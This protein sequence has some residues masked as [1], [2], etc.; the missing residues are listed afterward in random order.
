MEKL[1][2]AKWQM[3]ECSDSQ[4]PKQVHPS[5]VGLLSRDRPDRDQSDF[6]IKYDKWSFDILSLPLCFQSSLC[7]EEQ[8]YQRKIW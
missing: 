7:Y 6:H 3:Q 8:F 1:T 4:N 2:Q 5:L